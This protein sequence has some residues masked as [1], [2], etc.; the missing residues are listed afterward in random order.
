MNR[1]M[2]LILV[3]SG[4]SVLM[5]FSGCGGSPDVPSMKEGFMRSGMSA[6]QADCLAEKMSD[7]LPGKQYNFMANLMKEGLNEREAF[8]RARRK[9]GAEFREGMAEARKACVE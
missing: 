7:T 2:S 6:E 3:L 1:K 9:Y 4:L 8:T 5:M